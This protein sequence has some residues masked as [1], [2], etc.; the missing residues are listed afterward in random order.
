MKTSPSEWYSRGRYLAVAGRRVFT[1]DVPAVAGAPPAPPVLALHGF[2]TSSWDFADAATELSNRG[3]RV[4]LFDYTGFGFSDKPA[5]LTGSVFD[6]A[7]AAIAVV[8]AAEATRV[9]IWAHDLGT[10]VAT[11]LLARG[12]RGELP[13]EIAGLVLMNGGVYVEMSRPGLAQRLLMSRAGPLFAY[14]NSRGI[15]VRQMRQLFGHPPAAGLLDAMW[16]LVALQQG[17]LRMARTIR[18]M[19]ERVRFRDRWIGALT[20]ARMPVLVAW[21]GRDPVTRLA[22]G[23]R[24]AREIDGATLVAWDDLGHYPHVE[25]PVRAADAVAGVR[26]LADGVI[27]EVVGAPPLTR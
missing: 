5:D 14:F 13:F 3:R 17:H 19:D 15:F 25:D 2:P 6:H 9:L 12:E 26:T 20:R 7:D 4:I 11:E 8:Q 27:N 10:S 16:D 24:L 18:F 21:G 23:E 1:V 22:I